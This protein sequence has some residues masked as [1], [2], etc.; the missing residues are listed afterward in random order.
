LQRSDTVSQVQ[1]QTMVG[2]NHSP[3]G[4]C[5]ILAEFGYYYLFGTGVTVHTLAG[6]WSIFRRED[7]LCKRSVGR[8]HRLVPFD[9][10]LINQRTTPL[11][12]IGR[13]I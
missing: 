7:V 12:R 3:D 8:K 1:V 6:D 2:A 11:A 13:L 5:S 4:S 9:V 10:A